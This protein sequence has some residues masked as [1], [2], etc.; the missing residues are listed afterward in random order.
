MGKGLISGILSGLAVSAAM[1]AL[2]LALAPPPQMARA[3]GPS[4]LS[5][6]Q[7][8]G[9]D[10]PPVAEG[11]APA[12][13]VPRSEPVAS[14][15]DAPTASPAAGG[16]PDPAP[17]AEVAPAAAGG[18]PELAD[19]LPPASSVPRPTIA[20]SEGPA[21][22]VAPDAEGSHREPG[23]MVQPPPDGPSPAPDTEALQAPVP[24]AP[25]PPDPES[26]AA[27]AP[28]PPQRAP[29]PAVSPALPPPGGTDDG[30]PAAATAAP[31]VI[32]P[33]A[34]DASAEGASAEGDAAAGEA[35]A[36]EAAN[37]AP[38]EGEAAEAL[39]ERPL[40]DE[41]AARA[42]APEPPAAA[43]AE[44]DPVPGQPAGEAAPP[45]AGGAGADPG[46][47]AA[48]DPPSGGQAG[49]D[50]LLPDLAARLLPG[51]DPAGPGPVMP[52]EHGSGAGQE[53]AP[54]A[55]APFQPPGADAPDRLAAELPARPSVGFAG[56]VPGV[57]TGRLPR[58][59]PAEG[60]G[61][62]AAA[63]LSPQ[64]A[65]TSEG[66]GVP[67]LLRHAVVFENPADRPVMAILLVDDGLEAD[68]RARLADLPFPVS[69]VI[70]PARADA[71]TAAAAYR[72]AGREV[73]MLASLIP[74]GATAADLEVTFD[75]HFQL[76]PE[77]VAVI[78]PPEAGFQDNRRIAQQVA[79]I[80]GDTGHGLITHDR[81]LNPAEQVARSAGL[82]S[83]RVFR[84]L[85][86]RDENPQTI[87]R[88]LDRAVFR[89][90]Q[91]GHVIVMGSASRE[92]T[93]SGLLEWRME[94]RADAVA[95]APVSAVLRKAAGP[96]APSP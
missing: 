4:A 65:A 95:L 3:P 6:D 9:Q 94:G 5:P 35:A 90:A 42:D 22:V 46:D 38:A 70:D 31:P 13:A 24:A 19:D 44:S 91:Q 25:P 26:G 18:V 87:R 16:A 15:A 80:L 66:A 56:D 77:A 33:A 36:G 67:A 93:V 23:A 40:P 75:S 74:E 83:A 47:R 85:D 60:A 43:V 59:A 7:A 57:A 73:V 69:F 14:A 82:A 63:D 54:G 45:A 29:G 49:P 72:A 62:G 92:A 11:T 21:L 84:L 71:A 28:A 30:P 61:D 86:G 52:A 12:L 51:E 1:V 96:A 27:R 20:P 10:A 32:E 50:T 55:D 58:I 64:D 37:G 76:L 8:T 2:M 39:R 34:G 81:G 88:Y 41:G 89:A 53:L 78:D 48:A 68:E 79:V 17:S